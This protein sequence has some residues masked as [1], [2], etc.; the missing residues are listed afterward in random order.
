MTHSSPAECGAHAKSVSLTAGENKENLEKNDLWLIT[1]GLIGNTPLNRV[2]AFDGK[3]WKYNAVKSL[4]IGVYL[5]CLV[6]LNDTVLF[7]I[8]GTTADEFVSGHTYAYDNG[9]DSWTKGPEL[10][11]PRSGHA[12]GIVSSVNPTTGENEKVIVVAGGST[13]TKYTETVEIL[14]ISAQGEVSEKWETGPALPKNVL[15]GTMVQY[16]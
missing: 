16:Q 8:G 7:L 3:G 12:C 5:H 15:F 9:D 1:G 10:V 6:K 14:R 11:E 2:E 13:G 4:P